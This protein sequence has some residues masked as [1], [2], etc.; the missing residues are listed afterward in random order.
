MTNPVPSVSVIIPA[1]QVSGWIAEA[2][3]SVI[4]QNL[5]Y[6]EVI[7]VNDGSPDTPA[8]EAAIARFR[9]RIRYIVQENAGAAA[10]RNR[11]MAWRTSAVQASTSTTNLRT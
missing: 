9:E 11:A 10:A 7:L 4:G 5:P 2:L 8:L 3:E 6:W 1:H